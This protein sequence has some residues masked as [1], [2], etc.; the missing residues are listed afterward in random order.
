ME[1]EG[2]VE[3]VMV[4]EMEGRD[5]DEVEGGGAGLP[6]ASYPSLT[7]LCSPFD[8]PFDCP[9]KCLCTLLDPRTFLSSLGGL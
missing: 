1:E 8:C 6:Y 2:V 9:L 7:L 4:D 5:E 3:V